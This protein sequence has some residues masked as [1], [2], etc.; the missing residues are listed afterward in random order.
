MRAEDGPL[1]PSHATK[2][3]MVSDVM[4]HVHVSDWSHG[5]DSTAGTLAGRATS[6]L[7]SSIRRV[8][9]PMKTRGA[10]WINS[11]AARTLLHLSGRRLITEI[12]RNPEFGMHEWHLQSTNCELYYHNSTMFSRIRLRT[13]AQSCSCGFSRIITACNGVSII[14]SFSYHAS[15]F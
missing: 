12:D 6:K 14:C 15:V 4:P 13:E 1:K 9:K 7:P 5:P 3:S 8:F 2:T 11:A 10:I